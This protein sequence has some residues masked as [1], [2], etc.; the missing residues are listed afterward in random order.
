LRELGEQPRLMLDFGCGTGGSTPLLNDLVGAGRA[1][2]VD[3]SPRS[4]AVARER[5]SRD[6]VEFHLLTHGSIR[7]VDCAYCNGVFHHIRP[8]ERD[9]AVGYVFS[10]LG[11]GGLFALCENN[12]W[13]PGT[14]LVMRSIPF[15]REALPLGPRQTRRLLQAGGFEIL[16]TDFLFVFPHPLRALRGVERRL[17]R[18]PVGAQYMTLARK[19]VARVGGR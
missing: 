19:P 17:R 10:A 7:E 11:P 14:R 1:V 13:N 9:D 18:F 16:T 12:P 6:D 15:D 2:G 8:D 3:V 5:V 4:L